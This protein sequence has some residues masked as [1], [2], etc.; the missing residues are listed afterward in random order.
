[1]CIMVVSSREKFHAIFKK[2]CRLDVSQIHF[3]SAEMG[4]VGAPFLSLAPF[5]NMIVCD[6][7]LF[8]SPD[9]LNGPLLSE[10]ER[11]NVPVLSET[12]LNE[13]L[14]I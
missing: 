1:M 11:M 7:A 10:A 5:A 13:V 8:T 3:F 2:L 6:D 9:F 12:G 14:T 4:K